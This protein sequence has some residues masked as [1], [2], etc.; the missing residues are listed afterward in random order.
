MHSRIQSFLD[1]FVVVVLIVVA[2]TAVVVV[3]FLFLFF[4]FVLTGFTCIFTRE[5]K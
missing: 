5:R 4:L 2:A 3:L 1:P